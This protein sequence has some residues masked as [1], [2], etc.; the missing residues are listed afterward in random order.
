MIHDFRFGSFASVPACLLVGHCGPKFWKQGREVP[1][2]AVAE[3]DPS[4]CFKR[5]R[6][7]RSCS[8]WKVR[9]E[10]TIA[11]S[12]TNVSTAL[13]ACEYSHCWRAASNSCGETVQNRV[14]TLTG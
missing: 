10:K 5:Y 4:I 11:I 1:S 2:A 12:A 3:I 14:A 9:D 7:R 8:A 13:A 6:V